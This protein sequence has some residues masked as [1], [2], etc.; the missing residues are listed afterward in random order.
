MVP[1]SYG[2]RVWLISL[3]ALIIG[4]ILTLYNIPDRNSFARSGAL[5]TILGIWTAFHQVLVARGRREALIFVK[6]LGSAKIQ[7]RRAKDSEATR[8][9][10]DSKHKERV[11]ALSE[12]IQSELTISFGFLEALLLIVGTFVWGFGDLMAYVLPG[13]TSAGH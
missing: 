6:A 13:T 7:V 5:V 3:F 8:T 4:F 9:E 12:K 11:E 10:L 1:R 2:G